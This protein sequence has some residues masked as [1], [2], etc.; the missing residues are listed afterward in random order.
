VDR[1]LALLRALTLFAI[2][3]ATLMRQG[4]GGRGSPA[5][6]QFSTR[7][8]ATSPVGDGP[9]VW[10]DEADPLVRMGLER[11][12][13]AD[14]TEVA[15]TSADFRP[16]PDLSRPGSVLLFNLGRSGIQPALAATQG[17]PARLVAI[18]PRADHESVADALRAGVHA[19][20]P[21]ATLDPHRLTSCLHA[22]AR[23]QAC[24]PVDH[25]SGLVNGADDP[26]PARTDLTRRELQVLKLLA[27][28]EDTR[29]I[30]TRLCYA[31]RTIK[32]IVHDVL[33]KLQCKTRAHAVG[34]ATRERII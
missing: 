10:I 16:L 23:G 24:V 9:V 7:W 34:R 25:V 4:A 3:P 1:E 18:I 26:E 15:G 32:N 33:V 27:D 13:A 21:R 20:L 5:S 14:G 12:L 22:V 29:G 28:G 17:T 8:A 2:D 30:A 19:V 11:A 6:A 31:E